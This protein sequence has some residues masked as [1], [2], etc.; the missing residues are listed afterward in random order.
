MITSNVIQRT[1]HIN[2]LGSSGTCFTVDIDNKQYLITAKHIVSKIHDK[3]VIKLFHEGSWKDLNVYLVGHGHGE[4]DISVLKADIQLSPTHSLE[5]TS[6]G[7]IYGQDV[8]F[9]GFPYG[10]KGE[11]GEMNSNFPLPFV[12]KAIISSIQFKTNGLEILFLDGC[13]NPG[14]SGGPVVYK[15]N[16]IN[17]YKVA[18]VISGFRF[19]NEPIYH[20]KTEVDLTYQY[21]TGIIISYGINYATEIIKKNPIGY[22]VKL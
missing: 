20:G 12:K 13:N 21:N 22:D 10:M 1:F 2:Y 7:I 17:D 16:G 19:N 8:F 15:Q 4:I 9:L 14:F 18:S 5:P 11:V 3:D 6:E